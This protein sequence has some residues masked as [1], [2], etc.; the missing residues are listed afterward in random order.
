MFFKEWIY[1]IL[2]VFNKYISY[3]K[4]GIYCN[5]VGTIIISKEFL[6]SLILF[7]LGGCICISWT[8]STKWTDQIKMPVGSHNIR[9]LSGRKGYRTPKK[10]WIF[11]IFILSF[12]LSLPAEFM[13]INKWFLTCCLKTFP[14]RLGMQCVFL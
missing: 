8:L 14:C 6:F 2:F 13:V 3:Q 5:T 4:Y 9:S 7:F 10:I 11:S 12:W 1:I